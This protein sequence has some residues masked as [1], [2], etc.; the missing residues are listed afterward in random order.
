MRRIAVVLAVMG[1]FVW[2]CDALEPEWSGR[3]WVGPADPVPHPTCD[4]VCEA[5]ALKCSANSCGTALGEPATLLVFP[6]AWTASPDLYVN[7]ECDEP[8]DNGFLAQPGTPWSLHV[9]CCCM[10]AE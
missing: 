5:Q 6:D 9:E 1:G 3:A 10:G 7:L 2:G 8:F 4:D